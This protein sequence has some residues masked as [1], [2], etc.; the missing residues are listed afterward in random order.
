MIGCLI[1]RRALQ[2]HLDEG[3]ALTV[4]ARAHVA[5]CA[6]CA[7]MVASHRAVISTL[8]NPRLQ[9]AP[10]L[11]ARIMNA[12]RTVSPEKRS[13]KPAWALATAALVFAAV[14]VNMNQPKKSTVVTM[15]FPKLELPAP[16]QLPIES[17]LENLKADTRNAARA[18]VASFLPEQP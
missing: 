5:G 12:V 8:K 9:E 4:T 11:G 10:F 14:L 3:R 1:H 6:R 13:W 15:T 7:E 2:R 17:E 18:L 16:M